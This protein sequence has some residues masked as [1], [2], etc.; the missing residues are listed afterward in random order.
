MKQNFSNSDKKKKTEVSIKYLIISILFFI[1]TNCFAID[2]KLIDADEQYSV[3]EL[4]LSEI[5][6]KIERTKEELE[7]VLRW[8]KWEE[9]KTGNFRTES[10]IKNYRTEVEEKQNLLSNLN[11]QQIETKELLQKLEPIKN[12]YDKQSKIERKHEN[13]KVSIITTIVIS[14]IF[15][16]FFG[17]IIWLMLFQHKKYKQLLK[18]G[19]I[20]RKEYDRI[21]SSR[22]E[23]KSMFSNDLGVNPATGLPLIGNGVCDAGGNLR[24]SSSNNSF[25][26]SQDY[27]S[28]HKW[29]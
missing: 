17:S 10:I 3:A 26:Y 27:S 4:K 7:A 1:A 16:T 12:E 24:G 15:I 5:E 22:H 25:D 29:D 2:Q 9:D 21:M 18:E 19:K 20:S 13:L 6:N 14:L 8:L 28:R 23:S 11:T